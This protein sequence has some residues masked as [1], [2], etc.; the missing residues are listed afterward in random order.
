[1]TAT[2]PEFLKNNFQKELQI[3]QEIRMKESEL[4]NFTRHKVKIIEG[5]IIDNITLIKNDIKKGKKVLIVINT[6]KQ[7]QDIFRN[8]I[9]STPNSVLLHSR[10]TLKDREI[11]E[12]SL[13][14]KNLLVGTQVIEVSLDID[15]DVLYSEPAPIDALLQRFGR[16]N[17]RGKKGISPIYIF[18]EGSGVDESKWSIYDLARTK[19]SIAALKKI[20]VLQES[21]IQEIVNGVYKEGYSEKELKLFKDTS[22]NFYK[23]Y[24][25]NVPFI[26]AQKKESDFYNLFKSVE[27]IPVKFWDQYKTELENKR[28]FEAMKYTLP[29]SLGQYAYLKNKDRV[30][31]TDRGTIVDA[32]YDSKFG[33]LISEQTSATFV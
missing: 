20:D 11:T 9:G 15:Y 4:R 18:S 10:F 24:H 12:S 7:A 33:L 29:I 28:Y 16:V 22:E 25:S 26:D 32:E 14:N 19:R 5:N 30:S 6:V 17:R 13:N 8:L 27:V 31:N 2:M 23:F 21:K 1:M 3:S